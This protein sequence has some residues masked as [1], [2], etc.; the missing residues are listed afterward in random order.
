MKSFLTGLLVS[1]IIIV[2]SIVT[3]NEKIFI[4]GTQLLGFGSIGIGALVSGLM[5][6][7]IYRRTAVEDKKER[8]ERMSTSTRLLLF[9]APSILVL[10]IFYI[11]IK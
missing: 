2:I 5:S 11:F 6:D 8:F 7:N 4:Y 1:I 9:G 3:K 10:V